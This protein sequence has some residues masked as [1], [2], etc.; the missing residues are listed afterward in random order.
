MQRAKFVPGV[1]PLTSVELYQGLI[2]SSCLDADCLLCPSL[3]W[4]NPRALAEGWILHAA[5]PSAESQRDRTPC[6]GAAQ[7]LD[8]EA[9]ARCG[10]AQA[11]LSNMSKLWARPGE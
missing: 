4:P 2:W 11:E 1:T 3:H 7:H 8:R 5:E 10:K 9:C 6:P